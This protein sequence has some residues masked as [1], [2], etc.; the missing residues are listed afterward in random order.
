MYPCLLLLFLLLVAHQVR[1]EHRRRSRAVS[2]TKQRLAAA[3]W[4]PADRRISWDISRGASFRVK[5]AAA[6]TPATPTILVY[7]SSLAE[8]GPASPELVL[9]GA[10]A[11]SKAGLLA[12][13]SGGCSPKVFLPAQRPGGQPAGGVSSVTV[14]HR[15]NP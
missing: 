3:T 10:I 6:S 14:E 1:E 4:T 7:H 12:R 15:S 9:T 2:M 11:T 8:P 5:A 13:S